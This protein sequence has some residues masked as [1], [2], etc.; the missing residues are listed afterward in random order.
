MLGDPSR[1]MRDLPAP[2]ADRERED[3][4]QRE[5]PDLAAGAP[6]TLS[7][8]ETA[9]LFGVHGWLAAGRVVAKDRKGIRIIAPD[10]LDGET[11]RSIKHLHVFDVTQTQERTPR[12]A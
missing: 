12:A 11:V 2:D 8:R 10:T 6:G 3:T 1:T 9:R 7:A 5:S 4:R